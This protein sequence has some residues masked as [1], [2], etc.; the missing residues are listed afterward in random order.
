[1]IKQNSLISKVKNKTESGFTL[2]ETLFSL[3]LVFLALI[4]ICKTLIFSIYVNRN[5]L[6]RFKIVQKYEYYKY[7]LSS[8][9]FDLIELKQGSHLKYENKFKINWIVKNITTS[10]KKITIKISYKD[11][12]KQNFIYKSKFIK[13]I[14]NE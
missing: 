14:K 11:L 3:L 6:I 7:Y 10:L 13:E 2:I 9:S 4:F 12:M 1:M 8:K 5:S